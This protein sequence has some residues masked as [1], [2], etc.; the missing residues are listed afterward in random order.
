MDTLVHRKSEKSAEIH[1]IIKNHLKQKGFNESILV[2]IRKH[3]VKP[4]DSSIEIPIIKHF[5]F[6]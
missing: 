3:G 6:N 1:D 2:E 4:I 5:D